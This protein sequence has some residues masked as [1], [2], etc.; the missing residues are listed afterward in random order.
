MGIGRDEKFADLADFVLSKIPEDR[1][2][3]L[4]EASKEV[5]D[6]LHKEFGE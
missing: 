1:K 6:I 2:K 4:E 5:I 3:I